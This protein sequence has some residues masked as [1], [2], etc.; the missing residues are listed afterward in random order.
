M[1]DKF[2]IGGIEIDN[3]TFVEALE[4]IVGIAREHHSQYVVAQC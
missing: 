4:R 1:N 3:L 2:A